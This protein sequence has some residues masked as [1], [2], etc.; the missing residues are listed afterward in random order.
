VLARHDLPPPMV[1]ACQALALGWSLCST[2]AHERSGE[3]VAEARARS[4]A[5][6]A[7]R[8]LRAVPALESAFA[9]GDAAGTLIL[10]RRAWDDGELL[11]EVGPATPL[12]AFAV[13]AALI[14]GDMAL[15]E[16]WTDRSLEM[17]AAVGSAAGRAGAVTWQAWIRESEGD[18]GAA[19]AYVGEALDID[20]RSQAMGMLLPI[21]VAILAQCALATDGPAAAS[22]ALDRLPQSGRDPRYLTAPMWWL[23]RAAVALEAGRPEDALADAGEVAAWQRAWPAPLGGWTLWEPIVVEAH[24]ALGDKDHALS[25]AS[26]AI[27]R[28]SAWGANRPLARALRAAACTLPVEDRLP[29]LDEALDLTDRG[30]CGLDGARYRIDAAESHLARDD[31]APAVDLLQQAIA[32]ADRAG[33]AA[34]SARATALLEQ[35]GVQPDRAAGAPGITTLTPAERRVA[36]LAVGGRTNRDIAETLFLTEK[37]VE[38]HLTSAYRKLAIRSRTDLATALQH[39]G[40]HAAEPDR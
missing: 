11:R 7:P 25:L 4:R 2:V 18:L 12:S 36:D 17:S 40:P 6:D 26:V 22:A 3:L 34:I 1:E 30:F 9:D 23:A 24:M 10:A 20:E 31:S 37:T 29:M 8:S 39:R 14:A 15:A 21:P 16:R 27:Q 28:A 38:S 19:A 33:A 5:A 35:Q 32:V 13:I